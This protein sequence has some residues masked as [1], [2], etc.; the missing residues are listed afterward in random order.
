MKTRFLLRNR[1][2]LLGDLFL[3]VVS[4]LGSF[5]LRL[6]LGPL[7]LDHV[8]RAIWMIGIALVIKPVVYY[9]FGLYRR[10][11]TYASIQ[12]LKL[13]VIAVTSASVL[14]SDTVTILQAL[15]VFPGFSRSVLA[16]DWLLSLLAVGGLRFS[17][18]ILFETQSTNRKSVV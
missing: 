4:V 10:L 2:L 1:T 14:V 7:F 3:I 17:L 13:I 8:V 9:Q 6:N 16:I 12:E 15:G 5:V 18:R 11:W